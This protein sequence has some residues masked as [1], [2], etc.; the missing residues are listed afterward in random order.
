VCCQVEVFALD[1]LSSRGVQRRVRVC[2]RVWSGATITYM[3]NEYVKEARLR[4]KERK[5]ERK[6]KGVSCSSRQD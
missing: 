3:Y 2:R 5:K 6:K 1:D 4:K